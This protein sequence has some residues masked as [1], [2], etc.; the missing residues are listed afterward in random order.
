MRAA[1]LVLA[2]AVLIAPPSRAQTVA[3]AEA[4]QPMHWFIG[5]W[6]G[7]R[8][9]AGDPAK[10]I[11]VYASAATNHH[12]EIT[13]TA[14]GRPRAVWGVVSFD[15]GGQ[16]LVLRQFGADGSSVD[17]A[18]EA[19]GSPSGPVVFAS[20]ESGPSRTRITYERMGANSFV[21][22]I[23]QSTGGGSF[24]LVSETRFVR[25]D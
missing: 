6:K 21:E 12:L 2:L 19:P 24:S 9:E 13:E 11:R 8:A 1:A 18:L 25:K 3:P 20:A 4:W 15:P 22:R 23:E 17:A 16:S 14:G 7:T 10:V 5:T